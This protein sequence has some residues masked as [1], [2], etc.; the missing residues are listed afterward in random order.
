VL[1][2]WRASRSLLFETFPG[3]P[4]RG[5]WFLFDIMFYAAHVPPPLKRMKPKGRPSRDAISHRLG[6]WRDPRFGFCSIFSVC[7]PGSHHFSKVRTSDPDQIF[8]CGIPKYRDAH[9]RV[10]P[11]TLPSKCIICERKPLTCWNHSFWPVFYSLTSQGRGPHGGNVVRPGHGVGLQSI[12]PWIF[13]HNSLEVLCRRRLFLGVWCRGGGQRCQQPVWPSE[14]GPPPPLPELVR[15]VPGDGDR[16][17]C[18]PTG[19]SRRW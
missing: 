5:G 1:C 15:E 7:D 14:D 3:H 16:G 18:R 11:C 9:T 12:R 2:R 10:L 17:P 6:C 8:F 19:C 13:V 4:A